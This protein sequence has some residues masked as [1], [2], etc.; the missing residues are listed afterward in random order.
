MNY[1]IEKN[2]INYD[3]DIYDI[4]KYVTNNFKANRAFIYIYGKLAIVNIVISPINFQEGTNE[5][6]HGLPNNLSPKVTSNL[7]CISDSGD[8]V[9]C[10]IGTNTIFINKKISGAQLYINGC[11]F[12]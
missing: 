1:K 12:I 3:Y 10:Y 7:N 6:F 9:R 2:F 5:L 11:Y 8:S 4:S